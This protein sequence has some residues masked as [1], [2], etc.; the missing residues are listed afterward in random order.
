MKKKKKD[1]IFVCYL[2]TYTNI[3]L[4]ILHI[5]KRINILPLVEIGTLNVVFLLFI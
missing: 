2:H 3:C 5:K 4:H 1:M